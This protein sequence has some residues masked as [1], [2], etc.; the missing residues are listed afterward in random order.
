MSVIIFNLLQTIKKPLYEIPYKYG[1]IVYGRNS[2][3]VQ[4]VWRYEFWRKI[5]DFYY[6]VDAFQ[7]KVFNVMWRQE[8]KRRA[9]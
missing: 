9:K 2:S 4:Y 8:M 5:R 1:R 3:G 7:V 6:V